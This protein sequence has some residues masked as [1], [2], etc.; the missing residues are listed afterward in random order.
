M[1]P[2]NTTESMQASQQMMQFITSKWITKPIYIAAKLG[3]AD[4]LSNG[5]RSVQEI[6]K[7]TGTYEPYLYRVLRALAGVG[8]FSE[9]ENRVFEL[10]PMAESLQTGAMRSLALMFLSDWHNKAWEELFDCVKTGKIPFEEAFGMQ[11]FEWL[12]KNP[13]AGEIF[14]EAQSI[15]AAISHSHII[16]YYDFTEIN[17]LTDIGGGYGGLMIAILGANPHIKGTIAD[18][19]EVVK[20]TREIIISKNLEKSCNSI[21]YDFFLEIPPESDIY[22]MSHILHDWDDK[23]CKTILQ[24]CRKAMN[25]ESRLLILENVLPEGN[26]FSITRLLD[27]EVL[28]M[29]GG[30]ERTM[31]EYKNL[32]DSAGFTIIKRSPLTTGSGS[33][34]PSLSIIEL[35]KQ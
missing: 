17:T 26:E 10:T 33:G 2:S 5:P 4:I 11:A 6:A 30:C 3:I 8:I 32:F 12:G 24:N 21:D 25:N 35:M 1:K 14:N 13:E 34:D 16:N 15:K 19:P 27:L 31:S 23:R 20:K 7:E 18:L 28:V 22:I 9:Q 29:G